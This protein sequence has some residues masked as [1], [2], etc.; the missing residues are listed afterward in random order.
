MKP[1][2]MK[3]A[4]HTCKVLMV[5]LGNI[6]RSP[7]AHGVF[8]KLVA[9]NGLSEKIVVDSAGTANYHV[10]KNPDPRSIAAAARRGFDLSAQ[11]SR[12][13]AARDFE[14]FDYILAMDTENLAKMQSKC[15]A[16]H[17]HKLKLLLCFSNGDRLSVPDPYYSGEDGFELVL[18][19][20]EHASQRFLNHM[21]I[22]DFG[23][24]VPSMSSLKSSSN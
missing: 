1:A 6:C 13:V 16:E 4:E 7:T 14:E 20:V 17:Q 15:P 5:C 3:S 22:H 24:T 10:G 12:Q 23:L 19:L 9:N 18:D 11:I 2:V 21:L 8:E